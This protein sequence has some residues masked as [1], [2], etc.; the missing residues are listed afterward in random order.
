[1][2]FLL[3]TLEYFPF[4][5]G[6]ANYYTNLVH[7]WPK[8]S[9][10]FVLHNNKNNLLFSIPLF[11]WLKSIFKFYHFIKKNK[12]NHVIVGHI[13]PLG[14]PVFLLS[15]FLNIK[16]TV[17]LH[18]M[19]FSFSIRTRRKSWISKKIL[20]RASSIIC[21]NSY[22]ASLCSESLNEK[23]KISV[24]NPGVEDFSSIDQVFIDKI[25]NDYKLNNKKVLFSLGRLVKRKGFDMLIKSLKIILEKNKINN[26][27]YFIAGDGPDREYL[28]K[29]AEDEV[30]S[31]YYKYIVFLGPI[32]ESQ[33]WSLFSLC[34]IFTMPSRDIDGD[35]EGF[36]IVYLEANLVKR[37]V[38]AGKSGG[39]GDAV[40]HNYN[41]LLV[42][43]LD[44]NE[45]SKSIL[46]L[47]DD[48]SLRIK[49]GEQGRER[50]LNDFNW[51]NQVEKI[52]S[53]LLQK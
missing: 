32:S 45:I 22:V 24:F 4:K 39:V 43:P 9:Q 12:I 8:S 52:Y 2:K 30:G 35:F 53:F 51:K 41:G 29:L 3:V 26:I 38:I 44:E 21:A 13:L 33:K 28:K 46:S 50:A 15:F 27:I 1:M 37:A 5:G 11:S 19:D 17:I 7:Y 14:I 47:L 49:L 25:K 10:I 16:Y 36:G 42:N 18:G 34:D 40:L 23:N 31:D 6:V 20:N 48:E